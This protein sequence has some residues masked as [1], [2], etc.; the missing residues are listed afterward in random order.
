MIEEAL[1][2][3][4]DIHSGQVD[5]EGKPFILHILAVAMQGQND[6]EIVTGLL[7]DIVEDSSGEVTFTDLI[8]KGFP[9]D[10]VQA[11]VALTRGGDEKYMDYIYRC[12]DN[13]LAAIVKAY[14]LIHN[15]NPNRQGFAGSKSLS[16]RHWKAYDIVLKKVEAGLGL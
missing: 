10:I 6:A 9:V 13:P 5:K 8:D 14:D 12:I 4:L 3:A 11:V 2:L 15:L 16:E 7:H 1:K